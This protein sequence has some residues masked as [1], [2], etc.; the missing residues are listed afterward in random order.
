MSGTLTEQRV[1]VGRGRREGGTKESDKGGRLGGRSSSLGSRGTLPRLIRA[2]SPA[3]SSGSKPGPGPYLH[4]RPICLSGCGVAVRLI[5]GVAALQTTFGAIISALLSRPI[6][7]AA[8]SDRR[9]KSLRTLTRVS[10]GHGVG[11]C[12]VSVRSWIIPPQQTRSRP[13]CRSPLRLVPP[14]R[15]RAAESV[16]TASVRGWTAF[17]PPDEPG[18][19]SARRGPA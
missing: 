14:S 9:P 19:F 10:G 13:T 12:V 8:S 11:A 1:R 2:I 15:R 18:P 6:S 5:C 16:R 4:G 3:A 17:G 7:R